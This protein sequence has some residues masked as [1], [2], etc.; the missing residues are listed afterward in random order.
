MLCVFHYFSKNNDPLSI[1]EKRKVMGLW[2]DV[3]SVTRHFDR[4]ISTNN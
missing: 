1:L 3:T 2:I 4:N